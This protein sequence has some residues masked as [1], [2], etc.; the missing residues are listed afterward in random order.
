MSYPVII[1]GPEGE[2]WN[3]YST[4]RFPLGAKL[5]LSDGR[6]YRFTLAGGTALVRG[7]VQQAAA[8]AANHIGLTA[9]AMA[10]GTRAPTQLLGATA[11]VAN[12][13]QNGYLHISV[14]AD[15]GSMYPIAQHDAVLSAG[16]ITANLAQGAAII[17]AWTTSTRTNFVH[18]PWRSVIR[19]PVTTITQA[20]VGVAIREV[21][22]ANYCWVQTAGPCSVFTSGTLILGNSAS[23]IQVA[24]ALG[25]PAAVATDYS[26]GQVM[27][28]GATGAF[29]LVFLRLDG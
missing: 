18:N 26:V 2:Q 25:P 11:A 19:V 28:V 9:A 8:N 24:A 5:Q 23:Y 16:T 3:T 21:T 12:E 10:A 27:L 13:Y 20:L 29:S 15:G 14:T 7:E 6:A 22:A 4:P 17:T 1:E